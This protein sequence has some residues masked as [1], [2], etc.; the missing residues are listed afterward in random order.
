MS[1][2]LALDV[3]GANLK[4]ADGRGYAASRSFPLWRRPGELAN[5]LRDMISAAPQADR[6]VATMTGELADCYS[7][8]AEGVRSIVAAIVQ[9]A[10]GRSVS[11]YL[12]DGRLVDPGI[13]VAQPLLA[14]ASNWHA[15]ARF[16]A[17]WLPEG[18]G[19][20]IDIGST[21]TDIIPIVGAIPVAQGSTDPERLASGELVYTGVARSP[22]CAV[23]A[24]LPWHGQRCGVAQELFATARD[25]WLLLEELPE[26]PD[27]YDTADG[28]PA[29]RAAARDRLARMICADRD[30]FSEP[31]ALA[32]ATFV[33][34]SQTAG[35][36]EAIEQVRKRR[37]LPCVA[38]LCGQ[39][40]FLA[41]R[42]IRQL[43]KPF[44]LISVR[45]RLSSQ[46]SAVGP[47]HALAVLAAEEANEVTRA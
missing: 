33:A 7:T 8:K 3:G 26:M 5:A 46:L 45:Q 36:S 41:R 40:E 43:G 44:E 11:V 34:D 35:I 38:V 15:M 42:A 27:N 24:T 12:T 21:T 22:I 30:S 29:T 20:L 23:T 28:R 19:L 4:V 1:G 31:D 47:A 13:A 2:L 9:A 6:L 17:R 14:A 18:A 37:N 16:V 32:A 39:G 25:V 10:E